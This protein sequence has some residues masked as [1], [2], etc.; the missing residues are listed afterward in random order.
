MQISSSEYS[1]PHGAASQTQCKK[2]RLIPIRPQGHRELCNEVISQE[3][4]EHL[5][6]F[7]PES[8]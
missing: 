6:G 8:F 1:L 5:V 2:L 4:A 3:L 7:E